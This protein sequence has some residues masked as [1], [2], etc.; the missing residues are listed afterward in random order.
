MKH[1]ITRRRKGAELCL[2]GIGDNGER[3]MRRIG[4]RWRVEQNCS[5]EHYQTLESVEVAMVPNGVAV[6]LNARRH[7]APNVDE[8]KRCLDAAVDWVFEHER[9]EEA[10]Q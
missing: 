7:V 4:G 5:R 3:V 8:A 2:L 9:T 6:C 10:P 1:I